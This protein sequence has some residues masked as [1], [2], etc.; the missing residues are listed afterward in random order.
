MGSRAY[1]FVIG[2]GNKYSAG[3]NKLR[4]AYIALMKSPGK[5]ET[6]DYIGREF[7]GFDFFLVYADDNADADMQGRAMAFTNGWTNCD[8]WFV[9][10]LNRAGQPVVERVENP[11]EWFL[12]GKPQRDDSP[13]LIAD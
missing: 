10:P 2:D 12:N 11:E 3:T 8:R 5:K 9:I 7:Y 13:A 4:D 6:S 1:H